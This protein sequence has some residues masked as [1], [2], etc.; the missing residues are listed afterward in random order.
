MTIKREVILAALAS[1]L[2]LDRNAPIADFR[3]VW[4]SLL[5]GEI[6]KTDEFINLPPVYEWQARP[7]LVLAVEGGTTTSRDVALSAMIDAQLTL[8]DIAKE[9]MLAAGLIDDLTPREADFEANNLWGAAGVKVAELIIEIDYWS[10]RP[11][12]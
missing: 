7:V 10:D 5:D 12:G 11:V 1:H 2:G 9:A 3:A 6:E 4:R 8:L